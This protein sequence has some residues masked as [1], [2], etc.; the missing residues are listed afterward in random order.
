[1]TGAID[2]LRAWIQA[3][4]LAAALLAGGAARLVAAT[5]GLGFHARDDYF[6]VLLPALRWIEDPAFDW[7]SSGLPGAG[8]RSH[9][10]PRAVWLVIRACHGAG[11]EEPGSVLRV[12]YT[13]AGAY[14]LLVVPALWLAARRLLDDRGA[15]LAVWFAALHF[16]M[17]Y[18]G[19]RLLIEAMAMPPLALGIWAATF[20]TFRKQLLAGFLVGL[21]CWFRYQ[22]GAAALGIGIAVGIAAF[23]RSR[24]RGIAVAVGGLASGG[25]I[26]VALQGLFDL[27]TTGGFLGPALRNIAANLEPPAG[28]SRSTPLAY[29]GIWLLLTAPPATLVLVPTMVRAG[30]RLALV[31]WPFVTFVLVHSAIPHKEERFMLPVLPLFLLLLAGA[32]RAL[33]EASGRF[34]NALQRWWPWARGWLVAVHAVALLVACTSQSQKSLR[35]ALVAVREDPEAR[36]LISIGPELQTFFLGG[37]R[38][39]TARTAEIDIGWLVRTLEQAQQEGLAP[40]RVITF[41]ADRGKV[42]IMLLALGLRCEAPTR[43][44][45]WWLDRAVYALN[46]RRNE[47]R[48]PILLY[49]CEPPA[50]ARHLPSPAER[51]LDGPSSPTFRTGSRRPASQATTATRLP[52]C[53]GPTERLRSRRGRD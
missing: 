48:S 13:V 20:P 21:A 44:S 24:W 7:D 32:P 4:P 17:P 49:R 9:L 15:R 2:R 37:R 29:L 27:M 40:N 35:E 26:A 43:M 23:G 34:W 12:L 3:H 51:F 53:A 30:R 14:A 22:V 46:P 45:G 1:V 28:L 18:A 10:V 25:V 52:R 11:I 39:V 19:T 50:L 33:E 47:R 16:A 42:E 8:I 6:H 38:L 31:A 41:E 36:G 5:V